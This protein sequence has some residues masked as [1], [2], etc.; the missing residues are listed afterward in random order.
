MDLTVLTSVFRRDLRI[1]DNTIFKVRQAFPEAEMC[2]WVDDHSG[3]PYTELY[4]GVD[5]LHFGVGSA[6]S[7]IPDAYHID[8]H[9]NPAWAMNQCLKLANEKTDSDWLLLIGSDVLVSPLFKPVWE[10]F[11]KMDSLWVPRVVDM[12]TAA[13][14][15]WTG[16]LWPMTWCVLT[17]REWLN[18]V[19]GWD[20]NLMRG[21]AF[22]DN[23]LMGRLMQRVG[24]LVID[25]RCTA[26]HQSH[27]PQAYS[28]DWKGFKIN[29]KYIHEK[30]KCD[31]APFNRT[32]QPINITESWLKRTEMG[33]VALWETVNG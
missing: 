6:L 25:D 24:R 13:Q 9:K 23:D 16:R 29:E 30:W 3:E 12:D 8:E 19:G 1:F 20:E 5:K 10:S 11:G 22:D 27:P 31:F 4:A 15:C 28:D 32:D 26:W 18:D 7:A 17:K 14:W 21:M 2:I 33:N